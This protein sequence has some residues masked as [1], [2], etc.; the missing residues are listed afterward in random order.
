MHPAQSSTGGV[1]NALPQPSAGHMPGIVSQGYPQS[2][3][4]SPL[5]TLTSQPLGAQHQQPSLPVPSPQLGTYPAQHQS[6]SAVPLDSSHST[7]HNSAPQHFMPHQAPTHVSYSS[8]P[9]S[10]YAQQQ[11]QQYPALNSGQAHSQGP[12][13]IHSQ[14]PAQAYPQ[15]RAGSST[16]MPAP[17]VARLPVVQAGAGQRLASSARGFTQSQLNVLRNQILAFRRIKVSLHAT[18][19]QCQLKLQIAF[20]AALGPY[21]S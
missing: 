14:L 11:Q 4:V 17:G 9:Q 5:S 21:R 6:H 18:S 1:P 15:Q 7:W 19:R 8:A 2:R 16:Q 3:N 20:K 10:A 12:T 13:S